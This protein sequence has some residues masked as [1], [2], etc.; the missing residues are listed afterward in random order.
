MPSSTATSLLFLILTSTFLPSDQT[1]T[2]LDHHF[3]SASQPY[4]LAWM[5]PDI[6]HESGPSARLTAIHSEL[7]LLYACYIILHDVRKYEVLHSL[8]SDPANG[9][10][11]VF[12]NFWSQ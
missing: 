5:Q 1:R 9:S 2:E 12:A 4:A 8:T 6:L 11:Y 10:H 3:F 7:V